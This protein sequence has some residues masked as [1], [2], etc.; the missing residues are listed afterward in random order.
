MTGMEISAHSLT[1]AGVETSRA[2]TNYRVF[3]AFLKVT[4]PMAS[5]VKI[6]FPILY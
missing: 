1:Q 4:R 3:A 6:K 5:A 2:S